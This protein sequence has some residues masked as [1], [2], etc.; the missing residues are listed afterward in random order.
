MS[1]RIKVGLTITSSHTVRLKGKTH[2]LKGAVLGGTVQLLTD[3]HMA[4]VELRNYKLVGSRLTRLAK[5][6]VETSSG[7][8]QRV[9]DNLSII[10]KGKNG[11][12]SAAGTFVGD[13]LEGITIDATIKA[14][15][16]RKAIVVTATGKGVVDGSIIPDVGPFPPIPQPDASPDQQVPYLTGYGTPYYLTRQG[17]FD[18][19]FGALRAHRFNYSS[20]EFVEFHPTLNDTG[21]GNW[22]GMLDTAIAKVPEIMRAAIA[23]KVKLRV[24]GGNGNSDIFRR[25]GDREKYYAKIEA[26]FKALK[27]FADSGFLEICPINEPWAEENRNDRAARDLVAKIERL[28]VSIFPKKILVYNVQSPNNAIPAWASIKE[29]HTCNLKSYKGG[30]G[31]RLVSDCGGA[32]G[33]INGSGGWF[34]QGVDVPFVEGVMDQHAVKKHPVDLYQFHQSLKVELMQAHKRVQDRRHPRRGKVPEVPTTG[35]VVSLVGASD[36]G[37]NKLNLA[38]AP[39]TKRLLSAKWG[40]GRTISYT[41]EPKPFGWSNDDPIDDGNID[42]RMIFGWVKDG[43]VFYGHGDWNRP[44]ATSHDTKNLYNGYLK[45]PRDAEAYFLI[46]ANEWTSGKLERTNAVRIEG[47]MAV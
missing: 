14:P 19:Y 41:Y 23:N 44:G 40:S 21:V 18:A 47:R 16:M 46:L 32:I 11:T 33:Q 27:P 12:G 22:L 25:S 1:T 13:K 36:V 9:G 28:A 26:G 15:F 7:V 29:V 42:C 31:Y 5:G 6:K 2:Q 43:K 37:K 20:W 8:W 3:G 38:K 10:F 17:D 35:D 24:Y 30:S 4:V 34:G 45:V 39:I